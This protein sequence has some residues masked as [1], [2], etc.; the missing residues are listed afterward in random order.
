MI[1]AARARACIAVCRHV[2]V[3]SATAL[4]DRL[5][6]AR[7]SPKYSAARREEIQRTGALLGEQTER[8]QNGCVDSD[9][10][11]RVTGLDRTPK[12]GLSAREQTP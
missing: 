4:D 6:G 7:P 5:A 9:A 11:V 3:T 1:S 2:A 10:Y 8:V 12:L